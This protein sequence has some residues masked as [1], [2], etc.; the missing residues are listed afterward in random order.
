[1]KVFELMN[2]INYY[3][4][5]VT[6]KDV[7]NDIT[8]NKPIYKCPNCNGTGKISVEYNG[9]PEGLPDSGFVYEPT[10]KDV[11]C[12]LCKSEGYTTVK[13]RPKMIQDGWEEDS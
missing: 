6:L 7:L 3:G 2:L 1:M 4:D 9:Y 10:Y 8:N 13:Y 5:D 11:E 12:E